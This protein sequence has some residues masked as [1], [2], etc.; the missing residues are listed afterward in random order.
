MEEEVTQRVV[1]ISFNGAK[2]TASL[3]AKALS[4]FI[5]VEK[6]KAADRHRKVRQTKEQTPKNGKMRLKDL[7][8]QNTGMMNVE[9]DNSNIRSFD[10][11]ARKYHIDYAVKKDKTQQPPKY[12]VF[13]K[14]RDKDTMVT[15]FKEFIASNNR[16][17]QHEPFKKVL[18]K[19][20]NLSIAK[21]RERTKQK[22]KTRE[23][24]L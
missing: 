3:L 24:S 21:N 10:R 18:Q 14:S 1:S 9:V 19:F 8:A 23:Q 4:R 13:F 6:V 12:Y 22:T 5:N 20:K 17:R 11:V 15:A 7:M 2:L 16:K